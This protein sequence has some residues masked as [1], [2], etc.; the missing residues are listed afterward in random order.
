MDEIDCAVIGAGVV[1]LAVA[2]ALSQRGHDVIVL[3]AEG[4]I[5]TTWRNSEVIHA[6]IYYPK[7]SLKARLCVEGRG[8]LY[9][10]L[11]E[12][13]LPHRRCG[14]LILATDEAQGG[15]LASI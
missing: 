8:L 7:D 2:R 12:R 1:G 15:Q 5:G 11:Q 10:Y 9:A 14:K 3:E 4:P 13:G 6:A